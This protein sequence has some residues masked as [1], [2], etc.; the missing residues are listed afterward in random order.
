MRAKTILNRPLFPDSNNSVELL[1]RVL[2]NDGDSSF[3][4][5]ILSKKILENP[6][7]DISKNIFLLE[8]SKDVEKFNLRTDSNLS[9]KYNLKEYDTTWNIPEQYKSINLKPYLISK[10]KKEVE[11]NLFT[12]DEIRIRIKRILDEISE[13][14]KHNMSEMFKTAIYII[15]KF[16]ENNI[17]WGTGRGSAC[18]LYTLYLIG[19]HDVD[20][21]LYE[22]DIH[23]FFR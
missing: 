14:E 8:M 20:S 16:N 19:L 11:E 13:I 21:V 18:S 7:L 3:Y 2:W 15:D 22:L 5:E 12:P 17:V 4:S 6:S 1:D 10:L 9:L 23:E